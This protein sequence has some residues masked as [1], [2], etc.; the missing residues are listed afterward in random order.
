MSR[1]R[2]VVH[3][4][5]YQPSRIDPF[6]GRRPARSVGRAGPRLER[7]RQRR[8]LPAQRRARQPR[9]HVVGPRSDARRLARRPATRS[10]TAGSSPATAASTAMA[11]PFHH[12]ILPLA[13]AA[14][15]RT[16]IR[17]GLRDFELRFGRRPTGMWLPETRGRPADAPDAR[18]G[19]H[20]LHD[21]RAVAGGR[22]ARRRRAG[23]TG[24]TSATGGASSWRSTTASLSAAVSFEP[25]R[26]RRCRPRSRATGSS[27]GSR[28]RRSPT[29]SRRSSSSPPTASCT[30][31][32]SRSA[33]SSSS[34]SLQPRLRRRGARLR[35]RRPG[36]GAGRAARPRRSGRSTSPSGRRGA[37]TTASLRWSADC[38]CAPDGRWK[39][40]LRAALERLAAGIDALT[41]QLAGRLP[42]SPD[43]WAARDAYVD[44]VVGARQP[45][46]SRGAGCR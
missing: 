18:R 9:P 8:V 32:T 13:S 30:A 19:G 42:G 43:P 33:S 17:W 37:A 2:L 26:D 29:T 16:E 35:R 3:G 10:P 36:G 6:S 14:D 25:A 40:P 34:G 24:S 15:R 27:R 11:Q 28:P 45:A 41:E 1:G 46:T 20:R 39:A 4:H 38:A 22:S 31:T 21:P 23:R 44:V 7:P 5:F 12:T